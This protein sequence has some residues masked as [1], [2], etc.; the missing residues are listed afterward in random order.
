MHYSFDFD[1]AALDAIDHDPLKS[2]LGVDVG[3][4]YFLRS[5]FYWLGTG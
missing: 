4:R 2:R 3:T 1:F 5:V